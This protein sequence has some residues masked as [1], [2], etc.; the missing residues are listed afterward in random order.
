[1]AIQDNICKNGL[2]RVK[3]A[4]YSVPIWSMI[5]LSI[6][7]DSN[8]NKSKIKRK[9]QKIVSQNTMGWFTEKA[10]PATDNT[11]W[12]QVIVVSIGMHV[13]DKSIITKNNN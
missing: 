4:S 12:Q 3:M 10:S 6:L 2:H 5:H 8:L 9:V 13:V 7:S 11:T 1:M